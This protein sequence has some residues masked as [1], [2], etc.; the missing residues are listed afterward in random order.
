MGAICST[1]QAIQPGARAN[2]EN[3]KKKKR[4]DSLTDRVVRSNSPSRKASLT[5]RR[6]GNLWNLYD[7]IS[8]I[9]SGITGYVLRVK[10]RKS[11][12]RIFYSLI[13]LRLEILTVIADFFRLQSRRHRKGKQGSS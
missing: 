3:R 4:R 6:K 1:T 5:K 8:S 13:V 12:V 7:N 10:E 9:G 11:G 2:V